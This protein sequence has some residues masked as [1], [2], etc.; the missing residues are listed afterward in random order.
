MTRR[1][2]WPQD[3]DAAVI[4]PHPPLRDSNAHADGTSVAAPAPPPPGVRPPSPPRVLVTGGAGFIGTH[5]VDRLLARGCRVTVLDRLDPQVH[6]EGATVPR[7]LDP[8][9]DF[10]RGDV[11]DPDAVGNALDGVSRVVHLAAAVGVGQSMYAPAAYTRDNDLA[12]AVLLEALAPRKADAR[13]GGVKRLVVASSMSVYGEGRYADADGRPVADVAR[14]LDDLQHDR[15]EPTDDRGRPLTPLPTDEGKPTDTSSVYALNKFVQERMSL[16][17]G[18]AYGIPTTA[19][20]FFNVYGPRQS[21]SNPYTGVMAIFAGRLLNGQPPLI[22]EDGRQRRDFVSVHDI[23][24]AVAFTTLNDDAPPGVYNLG[25][26]E[27]VTVLELAQ[28]LGRVLGRPDL[29]PQITGDFRLGDIRHCF[30]DI[31]KARRDL[32]FTPRVSQDDAIAELADWLEGETAE[33]HVDQAHA[34]LRE[35]GLAV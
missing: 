16:M 26:G 11:A 21:L 5:V 6:G 32:G 1:N 3:A 19:F 25:S 33:D 18:A 17:L 8:A 20:R 7:H 35:R 4:D 13:G 22:Y 23:A 34:E 31:T 30:A 2:A 24:D 28:R 27:A 29:A 9:A 12:T 10:I 14:S 15:W